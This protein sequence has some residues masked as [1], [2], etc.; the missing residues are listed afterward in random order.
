MGQ[1]CT[2][3]SRELPADYVVNLPRD[4]IKP[5]TKVMFYSKSKTTSLNAKMAG[6]DD[7]DI[8]ESIKT[9]SVKFA[10]QVEEQERKRQQ[11]EVRSLK[12]RSAFAFRRNKTA[13]RSDDQSK[14][15]PPPRRTTIDLEQSANATSSKTDGQDADTGGE[16]E[17]GDPR[18]A[19]TYDGNDAMAQAA[20]KEYLK[21]RSESDAVDANSPLACMAAPM[22]VI[23]NFFTGGSFCPPPAPPN[24]VEGVDGV[25]TRPSGP[26][27]ARSSIKA[28][29]MGPVAAGYSTPPPKR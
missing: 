26:G 29:R 18:R 23:G 2:G 12:K 6:M 5:D 4:S 24:A 21:K 28:Q 7:M 22:M 10:D 11:E 8:P 9:K 14:N 1:R 3:G 13:A 17:D 27:P 25:P 15:V 16:E 20:L 19:H